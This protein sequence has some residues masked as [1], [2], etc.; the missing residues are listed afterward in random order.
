MEHKVGEGEIV[1]RSERLG[2]ALVVACEAP[3]AR[4]P[5]EAAFDHP[6]PRQQHKPPLGFRVLDDLQPD[7]MGGR[8]LRRGV[9]GIALIDIPDDDV[10]AVIS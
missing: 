9:A 2:E 3:E 5:R 8:G 7:P 10:L 6:A 1:V 4:G